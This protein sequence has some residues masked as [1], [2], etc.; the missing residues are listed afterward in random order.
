M[1]LGRKINQIWIPSN[2]DSVSSHAVMVLYWQNLQSMGNLFRVQD[3]FSSLLFFILFYCR[4]H[5]ISLD[6]MYF[7]IPFLN[8]GFGLYC[9]ANYGKE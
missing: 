2:L 6:Y 3:F 7:G 4:L 8:W 1:K 5:A 9:N